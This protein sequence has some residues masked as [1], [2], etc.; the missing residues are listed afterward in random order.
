M[1]T[2]TSSQVEILLRATSQRCLLRRAWLLNA[3]TVVQPAAQDIIQVKEEIKAPGEAAVTL[4]FDREGV[5]RGVVPGGLEIIRTPQDKQFVVGIISGSVDTHDEDAFTCYV[6]SELGQAPFTRQALFC[7]A[8]YIGLAKELLGVNKF[9]TS[10]AKIGKTSVGRWIENIVVIQYPTDFQVFEYL[11]RTLDPEKTAAMIADGC[12]SIPPTV[13]IHQYKKSLDHMFF[14]N[15]MTEICVPGMTEHSLMTSPKVVEYRKKFIEEHKD[16]MND[17]I[18]IKQLEDELIKLDKEW[19]GVGTD[20][21][22][23][24]TTFFDG[25]GSKSWQMHRKKLFLTTGGIPA[26]DTSSG[27]FDYIEN[28]L[29]EGWTPQALPSIVN[30]IRKGSYERGVET[31]K[32]GA[33]TKLVIRVFQDVNIVEDDCGT[34]RTVPMDFRGIC[35]I[36]DFIGRT[37]SVNGKDVLLTN[38]NYKQFDNQVLN[39]YSPLTCATKNNFCHKCCGHRSKDLGAEVLGIQVVK[40]TSKYMN[41]AMKNMHGTVLKVLDA[42]LQ[43][44]F[45]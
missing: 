20:H 42:K 15:H 4:T 19:M 1:T 39:V 44:I 6:L 34:K 5:R 26:F 21:P 16:R 18:V 7:P 9:T 45:L 27:K 14:L 12:H 35:K 28:S 10:L 40:I 38:D 17:P 43:D 2:L 24:A 13:E 22:D 8:D 37:I 25:L 41:T 3:L 36:K 30:E 23:P 11:N 33:E 32:G 29:S 31:Q